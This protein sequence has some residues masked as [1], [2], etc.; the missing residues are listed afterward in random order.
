M[1]SV[2][3][4]VILRSLAFVGIFV[5]ARFFPTPQDVVGVNV[6]LG[7]LVFGLYAALAAVWAFCDG[8][9]VSRRRALVIWFSTAVLV[10]LAQ[11]FL[12]LLEPGGVA[13]ALSDL[14]TVSPFIAMLIAVPS[15]VFV[16]AATTWVRMEPESDTGRHRRKATN[17]STGTATAE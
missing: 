15:G 14:R 2:L 10:G 7:L 16:W 4:S 5:V 8:L 12:T 11:P 13:V 9:A 17:P 6:G 3:I 1:G